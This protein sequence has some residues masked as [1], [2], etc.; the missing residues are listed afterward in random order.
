MYSVK[1]TLGE[2]KERIMKHLGRYSSNGKTVSIGETVDIEKRLITSINIH[3]AK[4]VYEYP[5][6]VKCPILFL[7][8]ELLYDY[9]GFRLSEGEST[10]YRFSV[11]DGAFHIV[12]SGKGRI[13]VRSDGGKVSLY[14]VDTV[15]GAY[16]VVCGAVRGA[17]GEE[18]VIYLSADTVL[19][20]RGFVIYGGVP[21]GADWQGLVCDKDRISAY[22]PEQCGEVVS[23]RGDRNGTD[24]CGIAEINQELRTVS[25]PRSLYG[26]YTLEYIPFA[27][28]FEDTAQDSEEIVLSPL[29]F[30]ALCYMCASDLCPA[31]DPELYSKLTYKYREILENIYARSRGAR[32]VNRFYG[33]IKRGIVAPFGSGR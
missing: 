17:V 19:D 26:K 25:L 23:L 1:Y 30:D 7:C 32:I 27:K 29:L 9:G 11:K 10:A 14:A 21:S 5:S 13:E 33:F 31:S 20:V 2:C 22:L 8:P 3:L 15:N 4:L 12:A 24:V 28:S 6:T 18:C 16:S